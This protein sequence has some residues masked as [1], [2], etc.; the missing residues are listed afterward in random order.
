MLKKYEFNKPIGGG[1]LLYSY[2]HSLLHEFLATDNENMRLEYS[3]EREALNAR[4]AL[5]RYIDSHKQPLNALCRGTFVYVVRKE[6][7]NESNDVHEQQK[8]EMIRAVMLANL[9]ACAHQDKDIR[10]QFLDKKISAS[11]IGKRAKTDILK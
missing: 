4:Q 7:E 11:P 5:A 3:D 1:R 10:E 2:E 9:A 6:K 8:P